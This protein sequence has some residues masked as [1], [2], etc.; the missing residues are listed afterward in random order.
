[1]RPL[2][3]KS[4]L[5]TGDC[6]QSGYVSIYYPTFQFAKKNMWSLGTRLVQTALACTGSVCTSLAYLDV[7]SP[8][9]W[10]LGTR[11]V[12]TALACTGSVCT[13]LAYLDVMNI[14]K[15]SW[16]PG[17]KTRTCTHVQVA[18]YVCAHF[19]N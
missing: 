2:S 10:S 6:E 18:G 9:Q 7:M 12:Q 11:L 13:S 14:S 17:N 4:N 19:P 8:G 3:Y 1:M 15:E 5:L 16:G